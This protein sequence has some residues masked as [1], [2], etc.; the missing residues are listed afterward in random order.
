MAPNF[1]VTFA[2]IDGFLADGRKYGTL[3][4]INTNWSDDAQVLY[5]ATLPGMAYG[6]IAGWQSAPMDRGRFFAD[7]CARFYS[8]AV[9]AE[10]APALA[11]LTEAEEAITAA[12]GAED[13]FRLWDDPFAPD[14]LQRVRGHLP[15]LRQ[16]RLAA[17]DAQERMA[18]A[19]SAG[20][21]AYSIPSL[22]VA[23]RL[24]DYAGQKF[25]YATE[26]ADNF[27][28]IG[29]SSTRADISFWLGTQSAARNHGRIGDLMDLIT[30][31]RDQYRQAWL[32][33]YTPYRM[34]AALGRFDAEYEYWRR[35]QARI[36]EV[37]RNLKEGSPAPSLD[38]L[39]R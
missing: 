6:T 18:R 28:K 20:G 7:Y 17:E 15:E 24:V 8:D 22:L 14:R 29:P 1:S 25:I 27:A 38:S 13:M 26:L 31:L 5:R 12:L 39:R 33:E 35:L 2:N 37:R 36:W 32:D 11:S 23:A 9:A 19:A 34:A 21:D 3:G 16:A 4:I 10:M 30:E